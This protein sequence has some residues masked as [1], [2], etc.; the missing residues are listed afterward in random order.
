MIVIEKNCEVSSVV[1]IYK[2]FIKKVLLASIITLTFLFRASLP[3]TA[4]DVRYDAGSL[5]RGCERI[6]GQLSISLSQDDLFLAGQCI[7]TINS[8]AG[9][10]SYNCIQQIYEHREPLVPAAKIDA[11]MPAMVQ[12]FVNYARHHPE[13]WNRDGRTL[14]EAALIEL[15]PCNP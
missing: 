4:L 3:A 13:L 11:D 8:V 10:L 6:A 2:L 15:W 9:Y 5:F 1:I 7:G 12:A 14:V